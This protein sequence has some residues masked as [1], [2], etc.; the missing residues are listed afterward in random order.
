MRDRWRLVRPGENL[1][2]SKSFFWSHLLAHVAVVLLFVGALVA[3]LSQIRSVRSPTA[4][5]ILHFLPP[6]AVSLVAYLA[7]ATA[8]H[9]LLRRFVLGE[10]WRL[11]WICVGIACFPVSVWS[12]D[13]VLSR[14]L[15]SIGFVHFDFF[16]QLCPVSATVG[17]LAIM[18]RTFGQKIFNRHGALRDTKGNQ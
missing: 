8:A 5:E 3:L 10:H 9:A 13:A 1:P 15:P 18:I 4:R 2:S 16:L 17:T 12:T 7:P 11:A 6:F 14:T